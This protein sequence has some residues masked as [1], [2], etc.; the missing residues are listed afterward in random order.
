MPALAFP[1]PVTK[2]SFIPLRTACVADRFARENR[3][4]SHHRMRKRC[5][6]AIDIVV[7]RQPCRKYDL[8][9]WLALHHRGTGESMRLYRIKRLR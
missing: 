6:R 7:K 3:E 8:E 4:R 9:L 2:G 5:L 1:A